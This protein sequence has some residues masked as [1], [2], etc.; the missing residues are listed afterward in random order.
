M[1]YFANILKV[2][3][4]GS[5]KSTTSKMAEGRKRE[6]F[7]LFGGGGAV[8]RIYIFESI[9]QF[10]LTGKDKTSQPIISAQMRDDSVRTNDSV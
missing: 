7:S 8:A 2:A 5:G 6:E 4:K 9:F 3:K 10:K 1:S